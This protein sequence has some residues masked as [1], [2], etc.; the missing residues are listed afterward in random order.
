MTPA[1]MEAM[2]QEGVLIFASMVY[3]NRDLLS[4]IENTS[5]FMN[6][7]LAADYGYEEIQ[8][9]GFAAGRSVRFAPVGDF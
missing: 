1:L 6:G 9:D 2:K 3:Q 4:L 5:T 7:E 8:G